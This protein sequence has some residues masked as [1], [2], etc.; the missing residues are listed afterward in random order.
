MQLQSGVRFEDLY[1]L[2]IYDYKVSIEDGQ[3]MQ[4]VFT[5]KE[6]ITAVIIVNYIIKNLQ[7]KYANGLPFKLDEKPYNKAIKKNSW[8]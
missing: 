8:K 2:F 7:T 3:E 4:T 6:S 5:D 1:K